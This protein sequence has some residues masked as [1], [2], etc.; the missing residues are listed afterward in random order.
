MYNI[1]IYTVEPFSSMAL[2]PWTG[3]MTFKKTLSMSKISSGIRFTNEIWSGYGNLSF[4]YHS[5]VLTDV[6]CGDVVKVYKWSS[7]IYFGKVTNKNIQLSGAWIIQEIECKWFQTILNDF[8]YSSWWSYTFTKSTDPNTI[9]Q[10]ILGQSDVEVTYFST[11]YSN[12]DNVWSSVSI[13]FDDDTLMTALQ[14]VLGLTSYYFAI[15]ANWIAY[16]KSLPVTSSHNL[17][18]E[19]DITQIVFWENIDDLKNDIYLAYN[20]WNTNDEDTTSKFTYWTKEIRIDNTSLQNSWTATAYIDSYFAENAVLKEQI[21]VVINTWYPIETL[22]PGQMINISNCPVV[23]K[24]KI[25][26]RVEYTDKWATVYLNEKQTL[27][28]ALYKLTL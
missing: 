28:K 4:A 8:Y 10:E 6:I 14:K 12:M 21:K 17:E 5:D 22:Y 26:K 11:D 27:E 15:R 25:I 24:E 16:F 3:A 18:F 1:K 13:E 19:K 23:I 9:L 7:V 2:T 20:W